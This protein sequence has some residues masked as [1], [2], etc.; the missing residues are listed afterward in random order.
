MPT[1]TRITASPVRYHW[2][3]S[4]ALF[5]LVLITLAFRYALPVRDGDLWWHML[6]GQ[7]FLEHK[8]LIADHTIFSWTPATNDTIYCTWLPDIFL[9]LLHKYIGLPGIFAFRY[10]CMLVLPLGCFLF[11]YR[12]KISTHPLTWLLCLL[13]V[14]MS[15]A[16]AFD[17]PEIFSYVFMIF[18]TWN[19]WHIRVHGETAWRNCYLFPLVMVI[20]V[21]SHGGFV[22]GAVFL[23]LI[24]L[25][26][27]LNIWLS[28]HN[29]LPLRLRK[30]LLLALLL[31]ASATP[32][33]PYGYRYPLQLVHDLLPTASNTA[34]NEKITAY[35]SPLMDV[36]D[37]YLLTLGANMVIVLLLLLYARNLRRTEWSSLLT[38]LIF[39]LLYTRFL[40]TTFYWVP[41]FLFSSLSLL[42]MVPHAPSH[43]QFTKSFQKLLP[44]LVTIPCLYLAGTSLYRTCFMPEPRLWLGFGI[45]N[46]NPVTEAEY[47]KTFF[48]TA[49]IANTYDQGAYLLWR[50]WPENTIFFD[51]RHFPFRHWSDAYFAF[52]SGETTTK[53]PQAQQC[54]IWCIGINQGPLLQ[55]LMQSGEWQLAFYGKNAAVLARRDL[56]LPRSASRVSSDLTTHH[57]VGDATESLI[58]ACAIMDLNTARAITESIQ[59][60]FVHPPHAQAVRSAVN[61]YQGSLA[62]SRGL[63]SDAVHNFVAVD[64]RPPIVLN[65]L[66]SSWYQL[67]AAAWQ[68]HNS[69][70]ALTHAIKAWQ[71]TPEAPPVLYNLGA[72]LWYRARVE[73]RDGNTLAESEKYLK[74]FLASAHSAAEETPAHSLAQAMLHDEYNSR[75]P[76]LIPAPFLSPTEKLQ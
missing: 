63:Y 76:L 30:H 37:P 11:A 5:A 18:L 73:T 3:W 51:S 2:G 36:A 23:L 29:V 45:G 47:I 57:N 38:N 6:Y 7:Y 52:T 60:T 34:Y 58:F 28:P 56:P 10:L 26:E 75:P 32:L 50:L 13:A 72:I 8:T 43:W 46:S 62:Y 71:L 19:W 16:A 41:V 61:L 14:I 31:T 65:M 20:W 44:L 35:T 64:P 24:G 54:D 39:A 33:T 55:A 59:H 49:R 42:S 70:E 21:N 27:L 25:G 1:Y 40:R 9:Y 22:F 68:K 66:V 48:P 74:R 15:Y 53:L 12:L 17:K 4:A 69:A 67:C